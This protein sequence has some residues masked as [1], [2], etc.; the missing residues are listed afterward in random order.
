MSG[1][2]T[3]LATLWLDGC[4]GCHMSLLD[5]DEDLLAVAADVD[6]VYGPLVDRKD[7]PEQVDIT[8]VEGAVATDEDEARIRRAR[9]GTS[10]ALVALGDCSVTGNVPSMRNAFSVAEVLQCA[11]GGAEAPRRPHRRL[12]VLKDKVVPVHHVVDVDLFLPGCPPSAAVIRHALTALIGWSSGQALEGEPS[13]GEAGLPNRVPE[14]GERGDKVS[15]SLDS[16]RASLA[17]LT[18]FGA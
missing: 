6:L 16:L 9:I 8:L 5:L 14:R 17:D 7:F 10:S 13:S 4:S 11:Y 2:K 15:L 1:N 3:R 12:P 18:R